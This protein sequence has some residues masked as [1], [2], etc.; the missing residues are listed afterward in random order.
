MM[1]LPNLFKD[2]CA[3]TAVILFATAIGIIGGAI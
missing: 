2:L 3:I 1:T